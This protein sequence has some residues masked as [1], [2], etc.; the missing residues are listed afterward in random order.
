M[1]KLPVDFTTLLNRRAMEVEAALASLLDERPR[2]GEIA[3]PQRLIAAMRHGVLNGGKRLRPFLVLESAALFGQHGRAVLRV[4]AALECIHCYSLVHDDL[5]AMDDDDLRR[6]QPTVHKAFDE[7][8][9]ILAGDSLLTYAFDIIASDE[10]ELDATTRIKLVCALTRASGLGG[11]AGGQAL[12]LMAET[13]KPDEAGI[14]TLQAMKTGALIRFACEAG[15]FIA[16]ASQ[17][18]RER[19][20]EFGSAIG[21]AFQLADDLLDVTADAGTMGKATGKDAAA[22]KATLVSLHGIDWTRQQLSGLVAQAESLLAPFGEDA[23]TLKQA[24]RFIAERQN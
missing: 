13:R 16:G 4:A 3:R 1:E 20:A 6:G 22:G 2:T 21:L 19:M 9:A 11:M 24:A 17:E 8:A 23:E 18:D 15:A 14:I 12:D 7:A 10:T 5:P